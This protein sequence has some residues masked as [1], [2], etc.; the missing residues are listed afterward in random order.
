MIPFYV[1]ITDGWRDRRFTI[2]AQSAEEADY[3]AEDLAYEYDNYSGE[4]TV[5][6]VVKMSH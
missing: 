6:E 3:I 2:E 1:T 5:S 4:W